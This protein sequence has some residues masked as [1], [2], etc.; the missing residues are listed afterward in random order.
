[1]KFLAVLILFVALTVL[2]GYVTSWLW[3][4]A[5]VPQGLK[6][7]DWTTGIALNLL[8]S[9]FGSGSFLKKAKA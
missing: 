3:N 4:Y 2:S 7:I 1:M 9:A 5:L 6:A 8:F